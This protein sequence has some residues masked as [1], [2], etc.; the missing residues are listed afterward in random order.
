M[1]REKCLSPSGSKVSILMHQNGGMVADIM[2]G[3]K[4]K[5]TL[6]AGALSILAGLLKV[7]IYPKQ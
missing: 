5:I 6:S 1:E 2:D 4:R 7:I 3:K